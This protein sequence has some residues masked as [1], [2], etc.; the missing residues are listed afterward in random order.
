MARRGMPPVVIIDLREQF[1]YSPRTVNRGQQLAGTPPRQLYA[2]S[3]QPFFSF[4][5]I[6][7]DSTSH[8][9]QDRLIMAVHGVPLEL[10]T[11]TVPPRTPYGLM[12][13]KATTW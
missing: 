2:W 13:I 8:R 12:R 11:T 4:E 5:W 9:N 6:T 1:L 3:I 7:E 10:T